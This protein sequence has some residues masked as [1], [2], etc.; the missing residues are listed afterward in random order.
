MDFEETIWQSAFL[1]I[2]FLAISKRKESTNA[3]HQMGV[4]VFIHSPGVKILCEMRR[5]EKLP[6]DRL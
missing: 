5:K 6:I 3:K 2:P 4:G 1:Q